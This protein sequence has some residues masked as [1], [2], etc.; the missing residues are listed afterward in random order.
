VE[1][2]EICDWQFKISEF[3]P[4]S[5]SELAFECHLSEVIAGVWWQVAVFDPRLK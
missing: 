4:K 2:F 3:D 1:K 5:I